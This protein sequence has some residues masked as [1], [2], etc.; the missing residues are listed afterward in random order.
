MYLYDV[1][2]LKEKKRESLLLYFRAYS[3]MNKENHFSQQNL[4]ELWKSKKTIQSFK[5]RLNLGKT[6]QK[7]FIHIILTIIIFAAM[8]L[9]VLW[10]IR[11]VT[12]A[13]DTIFCDYTNEH[14]YYHPTSKKIL[15]SLE[16][17][18]LISNDHFCQIYS[19]YL[20]VLI[21][22]RSSNFKV[23]KTIRE[24]YGLMSRDKV[25]EV[26]GRKID[27]IIRTLF[28]IGTS[29]NETVEERIFNEHMKYRDILQVDVIDSYYNLTA[30]LL[31]ALKWVNL[32]CS[33]VTFILKADE[34][35]FVNISILLEQLRMSTLSKTGNVFGKI[36]N[37]S[38]HLNVLREG[39][40]AVSHEEYPFNQYP[41]YAQGTSYTLTRNLVPKIVH[42]AQY[43]PYLHIEDAFIT[44]IISGKIHGAVFTKL[45][46]TSTWG[47]TNPNPCRFV[48]N[49]RLAQHGMTP[50]LMRQTWKALMS[51]T[52]T[53]GTYRGRKMAY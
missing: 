12:G 33:H 45:N 16:G 15:Y 18:F 26:N 28:V 23:R 2:L 4:A 11:H 41:P 8:L 3:K 35:I 27:V 46:K 34:D 44:G 24:T 21:P 48:K 5:S 6:E 42:T 1:I 53:C 38:N 39:K 17:K 32:Y 30:K 36:F 51:Y 31:H 7:R 19:P 10:I 22:S 20:L 25:P 13:C 40:W 14:A 50:H 52:V 29:N 43:L 37:T 49:H 9:V 47:D